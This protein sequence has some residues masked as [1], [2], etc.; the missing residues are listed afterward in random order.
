VRH[1]GAAALAIAV[2]FCAAA[3]IYFKPAVSAPAG[4]RVLFVN[5]TSDRKYDRALRASIRFLQGR[6]DLQLGIHL[7]EELPPQKSIEEYAAEAFKKA[8]LGE[9]N[10]GKALLF[11]WAEKE[12][13]FKIEVGY[14]LEGV[15]PDALC[16]RLEAGARTF[17]LSTT[18]YARRDFLVELIVTV[19]LQYLEY[20][21]TGQA[22]D[23]T[24]PTSRA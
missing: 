14:A 16:R 9:R 6:T 4:G 5:E 18:P 8:R 24:L 23:F 2:A 10:G 19:G 15:F 11:V 21:K 7:K 3:F 17:M 20:R 1:P 13:L 12:K 22:T